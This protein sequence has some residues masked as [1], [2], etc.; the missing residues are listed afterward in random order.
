[1]ELA[2]GKR[3]IIVLVID[4]GFDLC[5]PDFTGACKIVSPKDYVDGD[6]NS[7]PEAGDYHGTPC[8]GVAIAESNGRGIVGIARGCVFMP[9]HFPLTAY[10]DFLVDIFE[11]VGEKADVKS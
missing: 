10:E 5:H 4:D 1:M 7:F 8:A 6:S 9:V 2:M 11:E 3:N